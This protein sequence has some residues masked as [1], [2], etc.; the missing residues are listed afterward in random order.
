V[1]EIDGA[2][3]EGGGQVLRSSL[4]LACITGQAVRL[5]RIRARRSKPGLAP[6]HLMAVRAAAMISGATVRGDAVRSTELEFTPGPV[7]PGRHHFPI[8][9]AGSTTLVLQTI[10]YPLLL[11]NAPSVVT[12][13]GGTYNPLAPPFDFVAR[14][15]VPALRRMGAVLDVTMP[16]PGF[17]P[18]GGG[19]LEARIEP[20]RLHPIEL[21]DRGRTRRRRATA[22][23]SQLPISIAER[24]LAVVRDELA[25]TDLEALEL[26]AAGPGNAIVLELEH[27]AGSTIAVACERSGWPLMPW[28]RCG[29]STRRTCRWTSTSRIS[30]SSRWRSPA[31]DRF[32][33]SR[34]RCTRAPTRSSSDASCPSSSRW[35]RCPTAPP[36]SRS[37]ARP[38]TF[39]AGER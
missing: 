33:R 6:Q 15:F 32:A 39:P 7:V 4:A 31:A 26:D 13:E 14:T 27:D 19:T 25:F 29:V 28:R 5:R 23:V 24:E 20:G 10:L 37:R 3:G 9:T 12:I 36:A 2:M 21:Q 16:R 17:Y 22:I 38:D 11:A 35:T 18:V 30:C 8:G 34:P 1:I